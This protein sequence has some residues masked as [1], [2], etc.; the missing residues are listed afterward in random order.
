MFIRTIRGSPIQ[1]KSTQP[2]FSPPMYSAQ[3]RSSRTFLQKQIPSSVLHGL[4][5]KSKFLAVIPS[6][7]IIQSLE[8]TTDKIELRSIR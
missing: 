7:K 2:P 4:S 5:S 1:K 6:S 3:I 8:K